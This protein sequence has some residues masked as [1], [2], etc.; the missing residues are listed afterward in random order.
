[1]KAAYPVVFT[2]L[3]DGFMAYIPDFQANTQGDTLAEA[4]A[5][6]RDAMGL[7]GIEMED[8]QMSLPNPSITARCEEGEIVSMVDIDF[9][10]YRARYDN[11]SVRR[12]ISLPAWLDL[13]AAR[14]GVNVSSV[15]QA[16]LKRELHMEG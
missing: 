16:A 1:M 2:K 9:T 14:A 6:A 7:L 13:A 12:N 15:A 3:D 4:I 8:R 5:M 10:E 11:R